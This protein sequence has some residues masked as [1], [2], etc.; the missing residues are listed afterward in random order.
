M[1]F[2]NISQRKKTSRYVP[3]VGYS[4][5]RTHLITLFEIGFPSCSGWGRCDGDY[6]SYLLHSFLEINMGYLFQFFFLF[7]VSR[8]LIQ[9]VLNY[10]LVEI[11]INNRIQ[12]K[13]LWTL[14]VC[15]GTIINILIFNCALFKYDVNSKILIRQFFFG[16][17]LFVL[18]LNCGRGSTLFFECLTIKNAS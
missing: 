2:K 15:F 18:N 4:T 11:H 16:G 3:K 10:I 13:A 5:K 7:Q 6:L 14:Y 1:G 12:S 9:R 17:I 8:S